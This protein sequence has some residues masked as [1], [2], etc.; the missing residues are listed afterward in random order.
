LAH[1]AAHAGYADQA[2]VNRDIRQLAGVTAGELFA[3]Y[4]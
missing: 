1:V 3:G 4:A 2:D